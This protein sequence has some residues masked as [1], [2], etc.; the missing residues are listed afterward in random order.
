MLTTQSISADDL[1]S[2]IQALY[3][4]KT[5]LGRS[6][7]LSAHQPVPL[8]AWDD[9]VA[10]QGGSGNMPQM[11]HWGWRFLVR[12]GRRIELADLVREGDGRTRVARLHSFASTKYF[13]AKML[14]LDGSRLAADGRG[15]RVGLVMDGLWRFPLILL[16]ADPAARQL[17]KVDGEDLIPVL[18]DSL[19]RSRP[20][21]ME[22][23]P[24]SSAA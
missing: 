19:V 6:R 8:L 11:R 21:K 9:G 14:V 16:E 4:N 10:G 5:I 20:P 23:P 18:P 17:F 24:R 22:A 1:N 7:F 13:L 3:A 15:Y 2:C 12:A